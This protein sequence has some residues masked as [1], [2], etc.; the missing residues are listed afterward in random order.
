MSRPSSATSAITSSSSIARID[1]GD[2]RTPMR[3]QR[4]STIRRTWD[5]FVQHLLGQ[6]PPWQY[7]IKG[8]PAP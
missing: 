8:P 6:A 1:V 4:R 2:T 7:E 3:Y 5:Y